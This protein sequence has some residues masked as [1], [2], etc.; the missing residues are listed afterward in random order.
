MSKRTSLVV[1][2]AGVLLGVSIAA[3]RQVQRRLSDP[4]LGRLRGASTTLY[5]VPCP[6]C[7]QPS[8]GVCSYD[9]TS[10]PDFFGG[11][12][13]DEEGKY[14]TEI[15]PYGASYCTAA[16]TGQECFRASNWVWKKCFEQVGCRC[17]QVGDESVC[18]TDETTRRKYKVFVN[19]GTFPGQ[20]L[21]APTV[22]EE[23]WN[24]IPCGN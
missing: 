5:C 8:G 16:F 4:E 2:V 7:W 20:C 14:Y 11:C 21:G 23:G 17:V 22:S 18:R 3:G 12:G 10:C 19:P 6:L 9:V 13:K 24:Q 1:G 15:T